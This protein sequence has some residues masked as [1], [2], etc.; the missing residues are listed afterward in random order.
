MNMSYEY[1][2]KRFNI[3]S[4][5]YFPDFRIDSAYIEV[6]GQMRED[7]RQKIEE[8]RAHYPDEVLVLIDTPM[9]R[10]IEREFKSRIPEW[11]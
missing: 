11:E 3:P 5:S 10:Q 7:A 4:G 2:P 8:F 1:E 6:K 9:Y